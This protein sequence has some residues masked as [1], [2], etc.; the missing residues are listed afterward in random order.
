MFL[1][2]LNETHV[3][4]LLQCAYLLTYRTLRDPMHFRRPRKTGRLDKI[5]KY[6]K[7]FDLHAIERTGAFLT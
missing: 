1:P 4:P 3:E 7:G 2:A 5:A 6:L